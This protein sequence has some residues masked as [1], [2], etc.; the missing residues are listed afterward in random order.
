[1]KISG[2]TCSVISS[3]IDRATY[4]SYIILY[5]THPEHFQNCNEINWYPSFLFSRFFH[6]ISI[7]I[8]PGYYAPGYSKGTEL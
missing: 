2:Y 8:L 7:I 1:M 3:I 4:G 5:A 6:S